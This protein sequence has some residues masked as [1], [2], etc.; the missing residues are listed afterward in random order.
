MRSYY[1]ISFVCI[2]LWLISVNGPSLCLAQPLEMDREQRLA[3]EEP[4]VE[5]TQ[6]QIEREGDRALSRSDEFKQ[7]KE[8]K[9]VAGNDGA[10][11]TKDDDVYEYYILHY[12][13]RGRMTRRSGYLEGP[14]SKLMTDDDILDD[15]IVY[16]FGPDGKISREI[17]YTGTGVMQ[18]TGVYEYDSAGRKISIKRYD[19]QKTEIGSTN[20]FYGHAN[21]IVRDVDYKGGEIVKYHN[22]KYDNKHRMGKVTEFLGSEGGAGKDGVWLTGDDKIT[23]A[24]ECF[25]DRQGA[26]IKEKKYISPGKDKQWFTKDDVMQYYTLFYY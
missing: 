19:P 8:I 1:D 5:E 13:S 16:E 18:Y 7:R 22:F 6:A 14:D 3:P 25:Y 24:K 2:V 21:L 10:W 23:S 20:Y 4:F 12:D 15:Y 9:Y 26:K 11:F 17:L